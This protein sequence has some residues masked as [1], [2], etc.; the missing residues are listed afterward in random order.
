MPA[1]L[2]RAASGGGDLIAGA[3]GAFSMIAVVALTVLGMI[4][5]APPLTIAAGL[6]SL[7][8]LA[9]MG[10]GFLGVKRV[11]GQ[12]LAVAVAVCL[13][14]AALLALIGVA[15]AGSRGMMM[16]T[17]YGAMFIGMVLWS[18][19]G[20]VMVQLKRWIGSGIAVTAGV[21]FFVTGAWKLAE[22]MLVLSR[23]VRG[24]RALD[25]LALIGV[26]VS[27]IQLVGCVLLGITFLKLRRTRP[28]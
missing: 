5:R 14:L 9:C 25:N 16:I 8:A 27:V 21:A 20:A 12:A 15:G 10:G 19:A 6:L 7:V 18:L 13:Y 26:V 2:P 1:P 23:A 17:V 28:G 11:T 3:V 22:A 24:H 4:G